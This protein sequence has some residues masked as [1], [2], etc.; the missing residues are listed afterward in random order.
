MMLLVWEEFWVGQLCYLVVGQQLC[1]VCVHVVYMVCTWGVSC[2][3]WHARRGHYYLDQA[4]GFECI[5]M[6]Q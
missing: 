2:V 3:L 1:E 4:A 5:W 6:G